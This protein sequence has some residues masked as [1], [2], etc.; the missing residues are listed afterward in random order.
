MIEIDP[1]NNFVVEL[2]GSAAAPSI[3]ATA[4]LLDTFSNA[5]SKELKKL[6]WMV[7][8]A[9]LIKSAVAG[10]ALYLTSGLAAAA[11]LSRDVRD[12]FK[13]FDASRTWIMFEVAADLTLALKRVAPEA[14][15]VVVRRKDAQAAA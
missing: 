11:L 4:H 5:K 13:E 7:D 6:G 10:G 1:K 12:A 3:K 14:K 2:D 15:T 9:Y 8:A